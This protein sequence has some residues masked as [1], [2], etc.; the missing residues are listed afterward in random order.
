[1]GNAAPRAQPQSVLDSASQYRTFLMDYTP[2]SMDMMFGSLIGD[3]KFLKSTSC[4]CD[5]GHLVVKIY[6]KYD[7]RESLTSA[8][9]ALRR[10][11]LAFSVEQQPNVIPYA[12]FQLSSKYHVA[13]MVR[14]YFASNLY[15]RICSRPFLTTVEKKWIA[16][17]ILRALEQSHA[18]GICHG[19]IKQENVMVTSWNWVFLTDFAPFKPTYIPEDDPADYNYYFCAIDATRRGCSVAPERFYGKGS[20]SMGPATGLTPGSVGLN[21]MKTPDA[22][23]MLSKMADSEVTVEEVDKQILA[24]GMGSAAMSGNSMQTPISAASNGSA[25]SSYSRSRREGNLLESMDIFSAGCVI[26]ELFLGGK[27]LFDLPSLLKYRTGDSEMLRLQLKKI[28]DPRLEELLLHMLQLDP[29]A[30]LSAS[31]YLA[32]YS[33]PSGLFPTYFDNFLFRFL[34]LVLSRGGKVP[35]ARIRLVCKY[36]GRLV[37]EVAGVEDPEGEEF[38]KLR[39][40]EGYGSDRLA[41]ATGDQQT[42]VAQR[43]LEELDQKIPTKHDKQKAERDNAALAKIQRLKEKE[44]DMRGLS[45]TLQKKKIEKLHDQFNA[46]AQKKKNSLLL[47]YSR[48]PSTGR[49][50]EETGSEDAESKDGDGVGKVDSKS[51]TSTPPPHS[52]K[53]RQMKPPTCGSEPWPHDRNGIVIILS[54]IC[55]SLRHV[56]VPE[57]KLTALYLIRSLGQF[58]SDEA[59]LQRLIPYLLEVID[60]ASATVRA[61]ALRTITYLLSLVES[62]PLA[63]ASVF[64]QYVLPAMV[65]F[66]SDP[67]ELVRITFAECLPQLAETSRRFLEIAHAMKQKTMTSSGS[68]AS[69]STRSTESSTPNSWYLASSS[70]DKELSVLH[71][72]ISRFV[73]Q[74]TTPDQ[75]ASSSL[76][77]RALLVDITRL[78]VFFGRERTLDVVLP[79]LITFLNDPDWELR[80]AF[81]DYIVG[82]CSF[83]GRVA[84]EHNILPCIEQA[85]FDVQE[86]V[87]TKAVECLTGLCQLGLFQK[88]ISTLVEKARMTC[89]LLLHPSW[90]IRDAVLK[91]MGEISRQLRSV[92]ANV[93]LSPLLRPFLRKTMVFLPDEEVSE[94]TRRLRGCCRLHVSRENFDRAL[95]ASSSS[96]GLNEVIA[97]MERS[98]SQVPD[99]S[100]DD[101]G[102][103]APLA[104]MSTTSRESLEEPL[105]DISRARKNRDALLSTDSLDGYSMY[106]QQSSGAAVAS[107]EDGVSSIYDRRTTEIQSLKLMQQYVSIASM[108]MR[109]K[110]EMAKTEQAARMQGPSKSDRSGSPHGSV[111]IASVAVGRAASSSN[112][113]ARKLSRSHLRVLFVPDMRFALSTAQPLKASNFG[114]SSS[115]SAMAT[116]SA[117]SAAVN[118][119]STALVLKSRSHGPGSSPS[120]RGGSATP[121]ASNGGSAAGTPS[122]ESLSLSH[123]SKMYSL[124]EPSTPIS[125]SP[126]TVTGPSSVI[127]PGSLSSLEDSGLGQMDS[128][129][130]APTSGGVMVSMLNMNMRDMYGGDGMSSLLDPHHHPV[131]ASPVSPP[132]QRMIKKAHT[133]YH[134]YFAFKE[135]AMDP[136]L[137]NPRK[138]LARLNALGIPPLPPDLGHLR[139]PDGSPYSI[140][141][142]A[143]SPYC[144]MGGGGITGI[145]G[146]GG[147]GAPGSDRGGTGVSTITSSPIQIGSSTYPPSGAGA[148]F[149]AAAAAAAAI[150]G[151]VT[152]GSFGGS[153]GSTPSS[154]SSSVNGVGGGGGYL[155]SYRNWQPRK[156]VLVAELAEHSGAVTHVNAAQ[157]NSFL[158]SA[159]NDGTVKIWSVR[160]LQHSVNQGSRCTYDGQGGVITDMKVLTNSHSVASASSDGTVHVFRVDKVNSVG[161]NVQASG[162][163]ELRANDSAV[164]A[165]DYLNNVTEALLLYATRDGNIHAWDLR[166]RR[167]SWTLSISPELGYI[168]CM[169]HAMDVSWLA[170]GTSRGFLCMW[171]LRFLVLI[172]IWRHS[173]HRAIHRLQ[174]CLGLPNTL[175]LDETSV[176]LVFVA[177]GG[178]EVAVFDLSIGACR[179][180]FRTLEAQASEAEACKCP[181]LLHVQIPNRRQSVLAN[182]LSLHGIATAFDEIASSPLSEEPSVRAMLCP[183]LHLRGI[184]DALITGGEDCQL[185]YWDIRNGKQSYT[186]CGNGEAKSFYDNQAA[187]NDWWRM[188]PSSPA[189]AAAPPQRFREMPAAP[190]STTAN[191]TKPEMAWRQLSPPLITVCQ[192]SSFY[193]SPGGVAGAAASGVGGVESAIGMERRGLVPPSPAH[194]DCILDLTLVELG[195]SQNPSPMLVSSGRDAVIKVWK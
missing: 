191:I 187:P 127:P 135:S 12:D 40:K 169:T 181:T 163:K 13:F 32:K 34:V 172:R 66:Q 35:D 102:P 17:Q 50:D 160:S 147:S 157:D 146:V 5:E 194:T 60:D 156:N 98:A 137:G 58:T 33:S 85:L 55:S 54:L 109:S 51:N 71:K 153:V 133:T 91:L 125:A 19:D 131:H 126:I 22:A 68:A 112:P 121:A 59:R 167:E 24:M 21:S 141:S 118:S 65:P 150:N 136:A 166:M 170:V 25:P 148:S 88:K 123:V 177:A 81:F 94:V 80:G 87:I 110:L 132:R 7:E 103:P 75:K 67:D 183:S 47:D 188:T 117:T 10:L 149:N 180:V 44:N 145:I 171:D 155:S 162:L 108:Q 42:H 106:R 115:S 57:S 151:G 64:P 9:V 89:S 6:R 3:G 14:Q 175:P 78:C 96:S 182:V 158:A 72:M 97:E 164:M 31:G 140:Y 61:L 161:G 70:F 27:P 152:P 15:D 11:A 2:R 56:Q 186:I 84:V 49:L 76:V 20:A 99:D 93:F 195:S 39:L 74:L 16:F 82:V 116:S 134:H 192:D 62:F 120:H 37:R 36:Y 113:F 143:P 100:D 30:R 83:V 46:L 86:I 73:I 45:S 101:M 107:S 43:V 142:H 138:L 168:T 159:S 111:A 128:N 26:A 178:A 52:S 139:L 69:L 53:S 144:L 63:D 193:S 184:G 28:G 185:R 4:K 8:E 154:S 105:V 176:P 165:I 29:S 48:E 104:A 124:V 1:M 190:L 79:Q 173:S 189:S 114:I 174:P 41:T 130:F 90:W 18:K 92:D 129:H 119:T 77:K 95:L 38:F 23:M 122:L 179:A